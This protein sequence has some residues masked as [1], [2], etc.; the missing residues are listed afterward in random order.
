MLKF[1]IDTH[2]IEILNAVLVLIHFIVMDRRVLES[3]VGCHEQV[4]IW[5]S[6][7]CF[8]IPPPTE[9]PLEQS[10]R[11]GSETNSRILPSGGHAQER[12]SPSLTP[13]ALW[14]GVYNRRDKCPKTVV[15]TVEVSCILN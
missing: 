8:A 4:N 5:W 15:D 11:P 13:P 3:V 6:E 10:E 1:L 2:Y 7:L 12:D 14:R 9:P